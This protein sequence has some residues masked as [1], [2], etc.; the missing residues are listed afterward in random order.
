[1][2]TPLNAADDLAIAKLARTEG[3]TLAQSSVIITANYALMT[4]KPVVFAKR[5]VR[6]YLEG[7]ALAAARAV[8]PAQPAPSARKPAR[9]VTLAELDARMSRLKAE[10]AADAAPAALPVA[11]EASHRADDTRRIKAAFGTSSPRGVQWDSRT[12]IQTFG[13]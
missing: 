3:L 7:N 10:M 13:T 1:M 8:T 12:Q 2:P 6:Q 11:Q 4:S 9:P 5:L